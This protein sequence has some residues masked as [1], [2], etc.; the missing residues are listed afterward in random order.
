MGEDHRWS[1]IV[2]INEVTHI[3]GEL[4]Q[5]ADVTGVDHGWLSLD[6]AAKFSLHQR[7]QSGQSVGLLRVC[8]CVCQLVC[9]TREGL[10]WTYMENEGMMVF[11]IVRATVTGLRSVCSLRLETQPS[12][13]NW[14]H[15][16]Q[17]PKSKKRCLCQ[18]PIW[19]PEPDLYCVTFAHVRILTT[20]Q[21]TAC[22]FTSVERKFCGIWNWKWM[23]RSNRVP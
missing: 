18:C 20:W 22:D 16:T 7:V 1:S 14:W 3:E 12:L 10:S 13:Q 23:R 5:T 17:S 11:S 6:C 15:Q 9:A 21:L 4:H 19:D 8:V 2:W